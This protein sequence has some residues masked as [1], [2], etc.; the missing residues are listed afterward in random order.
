MSEPFARSCR[1]RRPEPK[2]VHA[3]PLP[4]PVP[5]KPG[6]KATPEPPRAFLDQRAL[7]VAPF[8]AVMP[9]G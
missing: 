9:S 3:A 1:E 5:A 2:V 7:P 4:P 8:Q 6:S